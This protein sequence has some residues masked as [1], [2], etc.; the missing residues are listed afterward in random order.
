MNNPLVSIIVPAYNVSKY[1]SQMLDSILQQSYDNFEVIVIDDGSSDETFNIISQYA[2]LEPRVKAFQN[3]KN[4]KI[5]FTLNRALSIA[6]GELILRCD[7]DDY[8]A[9]DRI[10][11]MVNFLLENKDISLVSTSVTK[12]SPSGDIIG[13]SQFRG[14]MNYINKII[15][16]QSPVL[17]IWLTYKTVYEELSGY[18]NIPGAEDYDFILR[19]LSSGRK[20]TNITNNYSYYVRLGRDGNTESL[21]GVKQYLM[22]WMCYSFYLERLKNDGRD[23][24]S[25]DTCDNIKVNYVFSKTYAIVNSL[26]KSCMASSGVT[27][28]ARF[29]VLLPIL[30]LSPYH[31][32]IVFDIIASKVI[33]RIY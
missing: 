4:E 22:K 13:M 17:H 16:Y 28:L 3:D 12:I 14:G 26:L 33:K 19:V 2:E 10:T 20:I 1:I 25:D 31:Y 29:I 9:K 7:G 8:L 5:V 24:Y 15:K 23:S 6:K 27:K 32:K 18:R 30:S 21:I 11:S